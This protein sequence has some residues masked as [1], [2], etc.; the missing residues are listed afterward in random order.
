MPRSFQSVRVK[1]EC[2]VA[3]FWM[4]HRKFF[5]QSVLKQRAVRAKAMLNLDARPSGYKSGRESQPRNLTMEFQSLVVRRARRKILKFTDLRFL[6]LAWA[7]V[8][9]KIYLAR[10][11]PPYYRVA[12]RM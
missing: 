7:Q 12:A 6:N 1:L 4:K 11:R 5:D 2:I 3:V 10:V 9:F 8:N